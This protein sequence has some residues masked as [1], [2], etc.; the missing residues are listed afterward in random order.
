[1]RL[2]AT[3]TGESDLRLFSAVGVRRVSILGTVLNLMLTKIA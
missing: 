3:L 2:R 1:M